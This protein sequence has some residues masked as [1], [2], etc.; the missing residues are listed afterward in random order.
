MTYFSVSFFVLSLAD[1]AKV[2]DVEV[3][4]DVEADGLVSED[5]DFVLHTII[6][7]NFFSSILYLLSGSSSFKI[8][9][10]NQ[11]LLI[12]TKKCIYINK[13]QIK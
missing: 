12:F 8:F 1:V 2:L 11:Q 6:T 3:D 13:G 4:E 7:T 10:T 5:G 9:P